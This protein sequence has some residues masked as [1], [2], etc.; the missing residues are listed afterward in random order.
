MR[1]SVLTLSAIGLVCACP[2][3]DAQSLELPIVP[4]VAGIACPA[5]TGSALATAGCVM[6]NVIGDPATTMILNDFEVVFAQSPEQTAV[7]FTQGSISFVIT[8][9]TIR[10]A[11]GAGPIVGVYNPAN[12]TFNLTNI[13]FEIEGQLI[14]TGTTGAAGSAFPVSVMDLA[15]FIF[16]PATGVM[17]F[18]TDTPNGEPAVVLSILLG[19]PFASPGGRLDIGSGF[20]VGIGGGALMPA[21]GESCN[22]NPCPADTN[23]DGQL[24]PTDFTAW[25]NAFNNNLPEC[26]QNG[27]GSCTPT[28]FTAWIANFNAGC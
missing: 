7:F 3:A 11:P 5:E 23:G 12:D 25:I 27:D 4:G 17:G 1:P 9:T 6:V 18:T 20:T 26:D 10:L 8:T 16:P 14:V 24:T 15:S 21:F 28:D 13:D 22:A 19:A 2:Q